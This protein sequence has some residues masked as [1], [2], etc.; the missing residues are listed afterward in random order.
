MTTHTRIQL[1]VAGS[2]CLI[3]AGL[4][5]SWRSAKANEQRLVTRVGINVTFTNQQ[6]PEPTNSTPAKLIDLHDPEQY[7]IITD[8]S[9]FGFVFPN[10][11]TGSVSTFATCDEVHAA[12]GRMIWQLEHPDIYPNTPPLTGFTNAVCK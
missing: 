10:G 11:M 2:I 4:F 5:L 9:R 3:L 6:L 12:I 8:G 1:L 7:R